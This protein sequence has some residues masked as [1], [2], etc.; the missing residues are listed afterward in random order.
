MKYYA[1]MEDGRIRHYRGSMEYL[2]LDCEKNNIPFVEENVIEVEEEP[3][4]YKGELRFR[5]DISENDMITE[6]QKEKRAQA[7]LLE[8]DP[9]TCQIQSLR[10]EEQTPEVEAE[11][12]ALIEE[13]KQVVEDIKARYPYPEN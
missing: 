6:K 8:K 10:D 11:I 12:A 13:R 9:L 4:L 3:V 2:K 7:Y 1:L 5:N